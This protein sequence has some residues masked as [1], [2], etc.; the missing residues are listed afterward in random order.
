MEMMSALNHD[1]DSFNPP[2]FGQ[3]MNRNLE[4]TADFDI[5]ENNGEAY[6]FL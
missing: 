2:I 4:A 1:D 5:S 6:L 3:L